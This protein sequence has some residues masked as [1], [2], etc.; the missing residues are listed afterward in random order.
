M[1]LIFVS[2]LLLG[3]A[4]IM[5]FW[6]VIRKIPELRV[7]LKKDDIKADEKLASEVENVDLSK[8]KKSKEKIEKFLKDE[9]KPKTKNKEGNT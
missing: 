4:A 6:L 2:R 9:E 5:V 3:V 8:A 7:Y 1:L